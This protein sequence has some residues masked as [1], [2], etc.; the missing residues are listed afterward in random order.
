MIGEFTDGIQKDAPETRSRA[1][2]Q[3]KVPRRDRVI[4]DVIRLN[5]ETVVAT[6]RSV[7][8][9]VLRL[10]AESRTV[11]RG[12]PSLVFRVSYTNVRTRRRLRTLS[13]KRDARVHATSYASSEGGRNA[14][15]RCLP[16]LGG[17]G[18]WHCISGRRIK[19]KEQ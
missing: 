3:L 5:H 18:Y 11:R 6:N 16:T 13:D 7:V 8:R 2:R 14:V 4:L 12:E 1:F 9:S 10:Q 15:R 19:T 17:I